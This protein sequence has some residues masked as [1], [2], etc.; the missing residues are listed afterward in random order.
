MKSVLYVVNIP[1]PY[2]VDFFNELGKYCK[3]TVIFERKKSYERDETWNKYEF[4]NFRAI[5]LN[6]Y[7]IKN[8]SSLNL[9]VLP[10]LDNNKNSVVVLG[11]YSTPTGIAAITYLKSKKIPFIIS[12]DGGLINYEES[13]FKRSLKIKLISSA[14]SWLSTGKATNEYLNYYG[15][16]EER[17]HI[18]PF[19]TMKKK[20]IIDKPL[21]TSEKE[22][23]RNELHIPYNNMVLSVGQF[24]PR[25]G[26]DV[27]IKAAKKFKEDTGVYIIGGEPTKEYNE[28]IK[29]HDINNVHFLSFLEYEELNK[30]Y[31]SAD[32]FVFPTRED[33]WGLV[34]NEA[35]ANGL[36]VITTS[37]CV[38]GLE[39]ID[40][41]IN[42]YLVRKDD[43][44]QLV[45]KTNRVLENI[46]L[47]EKMAK[48]NLNR[49]NEYT[50]ENMAKTTYKVLSEFIKK[51]K[52]NTYD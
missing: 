46:E 51:Q 34:I 3:L 40:K 52:E 44:D 15:A 5:F 39:M 48:N 37:S 19:T 49:A 41:G 8:F 50:I 31:L 12:V 11:N 13:N 27:L 25:K 1:S 43:V 10:Y 30:Y 33:V 38:A 47:K 17:T 9:N 23:L 21:S 14:T 24:I 28:L 35:M 29:Q 42:G 2:R 20:H 45:E 7:K 26:F 22:K 4:D 6:G 18:Y 32:A 16:N 36:P